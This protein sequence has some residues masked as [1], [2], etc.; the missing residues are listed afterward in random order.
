MNAPLPL[1]APPA[2]PLPGDDPTQGTRLRE[3]PDYAA[4][5]SSFISHEAS[6]LSRA[7]AAAPA[8][9]RP[10]SSRPTSGPTRSTRWC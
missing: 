8:L 4:T 6:D 10:T 2:A 9:F 1:A 3:I 7:R 5:Q